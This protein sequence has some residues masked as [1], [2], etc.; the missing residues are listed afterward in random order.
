MKGGDFIK[1]FRGWM[2]LERLIETGYYECEAD[3]EFDEEGD[4][5]SGGC[6]E[7]DYEDDLKLR[8]A[9][10][11]EILQESGFYDGDVVC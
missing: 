6:I 8:V 5:R 7:Y 3:S 10:Y 9:A 2:N 4:E 11:E 1:H